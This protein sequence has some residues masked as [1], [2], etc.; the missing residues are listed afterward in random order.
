MAMV[1]TWSALY[2]GCRMII[3]DLSDSVGARRRPGTNR[4]ATAPVDY[5]RRSRLF[6]S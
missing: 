5:L 2:A 6:S 1:L 3:P 4:A